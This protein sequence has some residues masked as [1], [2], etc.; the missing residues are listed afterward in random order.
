MSGAVLTAVGAAIFTG[1]RKEP[2]P[3]DLCQGTG[4]CKCFG[5]TGDGKMEKAVS[6][7][8]MYVETV[9]RDMIGRIINPRE[10]R[11]CKGVGMVL[12]SQCKGNGFVTKFL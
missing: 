11:V 2:E 5:C 9:K 7:D 1:L 10:C 12:C 8:D 6:R 3:C 4:G